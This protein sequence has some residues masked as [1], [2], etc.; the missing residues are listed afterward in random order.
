MYVF[1]L[2]AFF[3]CGYFSVRES[4]IEVLLSIC[5]FIAW[6]TVVLGLAIIVC[7]LFAWVKDRVLPASA[8]LLS[9][10]RIALVFVCAVLVQL[11]NQLV[12]GGIVIS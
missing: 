4:F 2:L 11:I 9:L 6:T 3:A 10:G 12:T 8:I 1:F 5:T 7:S